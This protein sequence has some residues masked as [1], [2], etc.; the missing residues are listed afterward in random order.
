MGDEATVVVLCEGEVTLQGLILFLLNAHEND[1]DKQE[2]RHGYYNDVEPSRDHL[3]ATAI[4]MLTSAITSSAS[5]IQ[6]FGS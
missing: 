3:A 6:A 4:L 1:E 2:D 5:A